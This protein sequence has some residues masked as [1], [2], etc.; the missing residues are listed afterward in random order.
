M[1]NYLIYQIYTLALI[2]VWVN[3]R[4]LKFK[5]WDKALCVGGGGGGT[6]VPTQILYI[7]VMLLPMQ[8]GSVFSLVRVTRLLNDNIGQGKMRAL[9]PSDVLCVM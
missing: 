6:R 1:L 5:I 9:G 2:L 4:C 8:M 3:H 7:C